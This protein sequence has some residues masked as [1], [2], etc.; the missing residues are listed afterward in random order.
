MMTSITTNLM[1]ENVTESQQFYEEI[2]GFT[3]VASVPN[4]SDGLQFAILAKDDL[5]LMV[6]ERE[7]FISEYPALAT[8]KVQPSIS[9]YIKVDN[10]E[11]IYAKLQENHRINTE[12]HTTFYGA[13]EFAI[14]DNSGYVLT[15][16]EDK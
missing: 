3:T 11:E 14:L 13:K 9:L 7:N 10:L 15:F 16:T 1:V 6:Q 4:Q 8:E 5:M 12:M 2:L